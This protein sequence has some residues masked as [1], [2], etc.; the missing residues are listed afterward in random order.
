VS[1]R[2]IQLLDPIVI[3]QIAAGEVVERP[4]SVVKELTENSVDAGAS[5]ITVE[6]KGGGITYIRVTDNGCGISKEDIRTA[7]LQHA[8]S[9]VSKPDDLNRISTLGFRGEALSSI[10]AVS[11]AEMVTKTVS[12]LTGVRI[13]L[14]GADV[15]SE[16]EIGCAEGTSVIIRNLFSNT[17]ARLKFLKKPGS[18]GALISDFIN[19]LALGRPDIGIK[20]INNGASIL[21]ANG[22][23]DLKSAILHVFGREYLKKLIELNERDND[24]HLSGYITKPEV[25]RANRAHQNFFINSRYIKSSWLQRAV[26]DGYSERVM[27]GRFPV[28]VL[29]LYIRPE[30]IDVNV[31]PC[32]L[33]VRFRDE[34]VVYEF[35]RDAVN[36]ALTG[37]VVIPSVSLRDKPENQLEHEIGLLE[38][39]ARATGTVAPTRYEDGRTGYDNRDD[40]TGHEDRGDRTGHEDMDDHL[41]YING[42]GDRPRSPVIR[43]SDKIDNLYKTDDAYDIGEHLKT[44]DIYEIAD[45]YEIGNIHKGNDAHG[46]DEHN[47]NDTHSRSMSSHVFLPQYRI[48]GQFFQTY[49]IVEHSDSVYIIDQHAAHE[50]VLYEEIKNQLKNSEPVSQCLLLPLALNLTPIEHLILDENRS[51]IESLGFEIEDLGESNAALCAVPVLLKD[52][53]SAGFFIEILDKLNHIEITD[54]TAIYDMKLDAIAQSACKAAV[55]AKVKLSDTEARAL[56]EKMLALPNPFTCPHGRP[57]VVEMTKHEWE[58]KFKR[59]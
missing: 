41:E 24:L 8:T 25:S 39:G 44:N 2:K 33:D 23:G 53:E 21:S 54:K 59:N 47:V 56:I 34:N 45:T 27:K 14:S 32:K 31:H 15:I 55:R 46:I 1:A 51:L 28:Y 3:N 9:K 18:E 58:K 11:Q 29:N 13:Q 12:D 57:T 52:P 48:I 20:Y 50:R 7:F 30:M 38:A 17:P 37:T 5:M 16:K 36:R 6:I 10:A 42:R 26:E 4:L 49:W 19:R 35:I 43:E 40:H 22:S